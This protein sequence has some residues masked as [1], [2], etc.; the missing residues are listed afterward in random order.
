MPR[1]A[2]ILPRQ[3]ATR[4]RT[5][6]RVLGHRSTPSQLTPDD[7]TLKRHVG[8]LSLEKTLEQSTIVALCAAPANV[9]GLRIHQP[10]P[11]QSQRLPPHPHDG[12]NIEHISELLS[13]RTLR[14]EVVLTPEASLEPLLKL[15]HLTDLTIVLQP[16][17]LVG[18]PG[19]LLP[20][21]LLPKGHTYQTSTPDILLQLSPRL[22][23][24]T[25][26][27]LVDTDKLAGALWPLLT[28]LDGWAEILDSFLPGVPSLTSLKVRHAWR[29][30]DGRF[31]AGRTCAACCS[32]P[33][34]R[35]D[36]V[37]AGD[38]PPSVHVAD[39][40]GCH[41]DPSRLA[42]ALLLAS[43]SGAH[44]RLH[45]FRR[46]WAADGVGGMSAATARAHL[47]RPR[48]VLQMGERA[49]AA[50]VAV[51]AHPRHS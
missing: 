51:P 1:L 39:L 43:A 42:H 12:H 49:R 41:L 22:H 28:S 20:G 44:P 9:T 31:S 5:H 29:I 24:L 21:P 3:S 14:L 19:G 23:A 37:G 25:V 50:S 36:G 4:G 8:T 6:V 18:A 40:R 45:R 33:Q 35:F 47:G 13:L 16:G 38:D 48:R 15:R 7:N 46:G 17:L 26:S 10:I 32:G 11:P 27:F 2:H 34:L 30:R